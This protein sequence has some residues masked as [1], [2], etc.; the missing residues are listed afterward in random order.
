[1]GNS[2]IVMMS[3]VYVIL[4]MYSLNSRS[5]ESIHFEC[6]YVNAHSTSAE[7]IARTGLLLAL[8]K[9]GSNKSLHTFA[10][11]HRSTDGGIISFSAE[12]H[13]T[14]LPDSSIITS[15]G[16][17]GGDTVTVVGTF[18][19]DQGRWRISSSYFWP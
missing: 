17:A 10:V 7:D 5:E 19:F 3:S 4:G 9:M 8:T 12:K 18:I 2:K 13:S 6:G 1:M 16:I 14:L 15:R 11:E